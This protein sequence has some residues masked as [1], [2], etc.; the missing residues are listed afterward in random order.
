MS[1]KICGVS[2]PSRF[3]AGNKSRCAS[4]VDK[5]SVELARKRRAANPELAREKQREQTAK[6]RAKN[7]HCSKDWLLKSS[8]NIGYTDYL[9]LLDMQG[10]ICPI[11]ETPFIEGKIN[12]QYGHVDHDHS[13]C[14]SK[15]SCGKCI[16]GILCAHC[17]K[18]LG[19]FLDDSN[20]LKAAASYLDKTALNFP[21]LS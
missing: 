14:A 18:G 21:N 2:D 13:C 20:I 15:K 7:P 4:C 6:K 3:R 12:N 11:C 16:R 17:N 5:R 19:F 8:Y 1:C 10:G 9:K